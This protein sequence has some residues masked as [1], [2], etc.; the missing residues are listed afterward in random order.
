MNRLLEQAKKLNIKLELTSNGCNII[1]DKKITN[2]KRCEYCKTKQNYINEIK[3][4]L[5]DLITGGDNEE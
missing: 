2:I 3:T 1:N 4:Y 5:F